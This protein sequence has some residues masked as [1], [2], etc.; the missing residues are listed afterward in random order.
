MT[1]TEAAVDA[2]VE[3]T[4]TVVDHIP[5]GRS[6]AFVIG[7]FLIGAGIGGGV[8]YLLAVKRLETK[9]REIAEAEIGE[10][11]EHYIAK[12][13]AAE[14][15][16]QKRPVEEIVKAKGYASPDAN[17]SKPPMAVQPPQ[18]VMESED[19][20]A[21]EPDDDSEMAADDVE[22]PNGVRSP[23]IPVAPAAPEV[24]NIFEDHGPPEDEWDW[25][26]ERRRRSP[27]IPY[28]IHYDERNE[29]EH[30]DDMTLTYYEKDDVV[31]DE[32]DTVIDPD[33]RN[34]MFGEANLDKFGHGSNAAEIVYVRND[35]LEMIF[36]IIKS[37]NSYAEEVHGLSHEGYDRGN[38]ERMRRRERDEP[39]ER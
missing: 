30:Y 3:A 34:A 32:R 9:Y 12:A 22:G 29:F 20:A 8:G 6:N 38:L 26:E 5:T 35:R 31:C 1:A 11:R 36:E 27:D 15:A 18:S 2:A 25:H 13:R 37:P 10:M 17:A 16:A 33:R 14:S 39:E 4:E 23:D 7:A 19:E 21:G 28:V 24:R